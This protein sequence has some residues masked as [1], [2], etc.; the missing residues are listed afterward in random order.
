MKKKCILIAGISAITILALWFWYPVRLLQVK[1][2]GSGKV[3]VQWKVL[4]GQ[5]FTYSFTHSYELQPV[6]ERY[7]I[8]PEG[9]IV[10]SELR[11]KALAYDDKEITYP[12]GFRIE[13]GTGVIS[14]IDLNYRKPLESV[15]IRVAY[16]V[17]Q[18][19]SIGR[20]E[21]FLTSLAPAGTLLEVRVFQGPRP[22]SLVKEVITWME[23]NNP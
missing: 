11:F 23:K 5:V 21:I 17:P 22:L 6:W 19:L 4:P 9:S 15:P 16:T 10:L 13:N 18:K 8:T 14:D 12:K 2:P 1:D 7:I 20:E 3:L